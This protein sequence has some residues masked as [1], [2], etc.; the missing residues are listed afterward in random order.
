MQ[1]LKYNYVLLCI[2]LQILLL[3][4]LLL[5][6]KISIHERNP[7]K[8]VSK[9]EKCSRFWIYFLRNDKNVPGKQKKMQ[10]RILTNTR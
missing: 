8:K 5:Y 3:R 2:L 7:Y 10:M 9:T 6:S 1:I 4:I